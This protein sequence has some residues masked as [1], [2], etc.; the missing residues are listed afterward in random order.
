MSEPF[1]NDFWYTPPY[2]MNCVKQFFGFAGFGDP[3]PV[4]PEFNGLQHTWLPECYINPPYSRKLRRA[5]IQKGIKEYKGG[6]FLWLLNFG[7]NIDHWDLHQRSSS[8]CLPET[9]IRFTPGHPAL[10]DGKSPMYDS[11]FIL[12][13]DP[14]GFKEAF[15]PLGKAYT[16]LS[17]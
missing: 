6:R 16:S 17:I 4:N 3:C 2:V 8:V 1:P 7:N 11:I 14:S 10:G 5:F 15:A 13:G 9:R 12:W